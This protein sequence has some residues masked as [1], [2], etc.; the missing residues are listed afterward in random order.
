MTSVQLE[1]ILVWPEALWL[2]G[3]NKAHSVVMHQLTSPVLHSVSASVLSL[4]PL[5]GPFTVY[6]QLTF[7]VGL[8]VWECA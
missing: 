3:Q 1:G 8:Q 2:A 6:R 5:E 4:L 7:Q